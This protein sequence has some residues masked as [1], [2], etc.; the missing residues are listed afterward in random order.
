MGQSAEA[1]WAEMSA[2]EHFVQ[3]YEADDVFAATLA[4]FVADGLRGGQAAVVI[5]TPLHRRE[6]VDRLSAMGLDLA[7]AMADDRLILLD[8]EEVIGIFMRN[9]WPDEELFASVIEEI[10]GRAG[11]GGRKVR[12]FGEMVAILWARGHCGA[13]VRLEYLWHRLCEK[14]NFPLFCA[15]PKTGFTQNPAESI[16]EL[17]AAHSKVLAA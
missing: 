12:A 14:E 16:A 5:A 2:C 3:I 10:L 7:R 1:F 9:G 4:S 13:T 11:R 8:A 17:C 15:Y 6:L